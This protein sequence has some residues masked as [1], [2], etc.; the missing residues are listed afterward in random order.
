MGHDTRQVRGGIVDS[1]PAAHPAVCLQERSRPAATALS[2]LRSGTKSAEMVGAVA[3]A[4]G[5]RLEHGLR[6]P[7]GGTR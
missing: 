6:A 2:P 1:Q 3:I 5:A 4:S 7:E